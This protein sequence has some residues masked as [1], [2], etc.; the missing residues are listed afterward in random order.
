MM[1]SR[2]SSPMH[3]DLGG[4]RAL[5]TGGGTGIGRSIAKGLARCGASVAVNYSRSE[6][7][8]EDT[9]RDIE[10]AGGRA[11]AVRADVTDEEQVKHL[12]ETTS[13]TLGGLDI[14]MANAGGPTVRC[15]TQELSDAQ[16]DGDLDLN[17]KAVLY[18]VKHAVPR[19]PD[20]RG[21][22]IVTGSI[23]A[24]SG[25]APGGLPYAA[26]KGAINNMVRGWAKEFAPRG[27]TVNGI[28]PGIIWTRIHEDGT[29]PQDYKELIKRVPLGRD[30]TP[31]DC[32]GAV[33]L[34]ASNDGA[35]I[36]GQIIE[37]NGG[38]AMP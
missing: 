15:P 26:A 5:V 13:S 1:M 8:A 24:R 25:G 27:I 3:V 2:K 18:C 36:T 23:S 32:V 31:E 4:L 38:M 10:E 14:L 7:D 22:I 19:L 6:K 12:I 17:C 16:W 34:L 37:I 30:G 21:R 20:D 35:Y 33:L 11:V 28:A 9:V 29:D